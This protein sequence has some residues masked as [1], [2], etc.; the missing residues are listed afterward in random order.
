MALT[1]QELKQ[2]KRNWWYWQER[3]AA[4]QAELTERSIAQTEK[5][6]ARYYAR[7]QQ[8]VIG[9]FEATYNKLLTAVAEGK[10]P[11]PADLYKLD[12]YWQM[13]GQLKAL[14]LKLGDK[15]AALLG[16]RFAK[17]YRAIYESLALQSSGAFSK[18]DADV[19]K[20]MVNQ[21]WCADG[22]TWSNRVWDNTELLQQRLN[23]SL[24]ECV[25]AG[26]KPSA[27]KELLQ[28]EFGVSF[29]RADTLVRT[30]MS[31]IQNQAARDRYRAEGV[32]EF[33]V[34]ADKDERRCDV[35]G[36]LHKKRFPINA[37]IPIPAH[38]RCRCCILPV[39]DVEAPKQTESLGYKEDPQ[40]EKTKPKTQ[41]QQQN[42]TLQNNNGNIQL[43]Q[44][45]QRAQDKV[46]ELQ[47]QGDL[48]FYKR[49]KS[50][51]KHAED[52]TGKTGDAA[53]AEYEKMASEFLK[54]DIDGV[55]MDGF[56]SNGGW[57]FK[58]EK[59]TGLF[60]VLSDKGT[61]STFFI[62]DKETPEEYWK[63]QIE[64]Y[65]PKE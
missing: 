28:N 13:Q 59:E 4:A 51:Q 44:H 41:P 37:K 1:R 24:I 17:Q 64:L 7:T 42:L 14:L 38:P 65:K 11:T 15:Q 33:E 63:K 50:H 21:I 58:I 54:K 20:Q 61:I 9:L 49:S 30:E 56:I 27:L 5:Q 8:E 16:D 48:H 22:K 6:L 32:E 57:L 10:Q 29:S 26:R 31:H 43:D 45:Q 52:L 2:D 19:A 12:S 35:C 60:G 39:V 62:P 55:K 53:W 3:G 40:Q 25:V 23:E 47:Q 36:E 18:V 46:K 34:W